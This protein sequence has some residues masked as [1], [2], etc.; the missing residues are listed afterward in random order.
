M[1]ELFSWCKL[2]LENWKIIVGILTFLG[3]IAGNGVLAV[4]NTEKSEQIE[5]ATHAVKTM[6][7]LIHENKERIIEKDIVKTVHKTTVIRDCGECAVI[8]RS[9]S[10]HLERFH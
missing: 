8:K 6:S 5:S 9:F 2:C 7:G 4:S 1:A 3:S 10:D